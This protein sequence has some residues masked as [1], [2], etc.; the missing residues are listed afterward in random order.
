MKK[1]CDLPP[2]VVEINQCLAAMARWSS[3]DTRG[4]E[5]GS[6]TDLLTRAAK[7]IERLDTEVKSLT[8]ASLP[9]ADR[10]PLPIPDDF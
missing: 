6:P 8:R 4:I 9:L 10:L 2:I 3:E 7:E 1:N 5:P